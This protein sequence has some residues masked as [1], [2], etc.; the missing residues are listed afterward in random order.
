[1]N[2]L[3]SAMVEEW[4]MSTI[5]SS[6]RLLYSYSFSLIGIMPSEPGTNYSPAQTLNTG[7]NYLPVQ[8]SVR[9]HPFVNVFIVLTM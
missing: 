1:M 3:E 5:F 2:H 7:S 9:A 6:S 8:Q 4:Y